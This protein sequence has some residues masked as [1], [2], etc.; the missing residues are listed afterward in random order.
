MARLENPVP[1]DFHFAAP[2]EVDGT[3][4]FYLTVPGSAEMLG[5]RA[6]AKV[7]G[8]MDGHPFAATLMSSGSGPHWLPLRLALRKM[9]GKSAAGDVLTVHLTTRLS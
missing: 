6:P 8:T 1:L 5:T 3:F 2:I 9:V 4:A 7:E